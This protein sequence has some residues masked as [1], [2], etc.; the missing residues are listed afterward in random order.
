MSRW[1]DAIRRRLGTDTREVETRMDRMQA[2][3]RELERT[4]R[5][6]QQEIAR[7]KSADPAPIAPDPR[8]SV[9][10]AAARAP[11]AV[12]DNA[13]KTLWIDDQERMGCGTCIDFSSTVFKIMDNAKAVVVSQDGPMDRIQA[14]IEACPVTCI[15]WK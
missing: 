10:T 9:P 15:Y 7:A 14:A 3:L 1:M 8:P 12:A 6:L 5:N 13:Q 2:D 4:L 11:D